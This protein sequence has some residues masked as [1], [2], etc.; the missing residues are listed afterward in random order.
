MGCWRCMNLNKT[1]KRMLLNIDNLPAPSPLKSRDQHRSLFWKDRWLARQKTSN[2][3]KM[4]QIK[5]KERPTSLLQGSDQNS[6]LTPQLQNNSTHVYDSSLET[7]L[8]YSC[9]YCFILIAFPFLVNFFYENK[10]WML[11]TGCWDWDMKL[12]DI[13]FLITVKTIL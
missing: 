11:V 12:L 9:F 1:K 4:K 10:I 13:K 6:H 8:T 3:S 2:L 7:L 5:N